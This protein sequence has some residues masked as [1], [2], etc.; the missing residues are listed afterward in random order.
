MSKY[1]YI[2]DDINIEPTNYEYIGQQNSSETFTQNDKPNNRSYDLREL[3]NESREFHDQEDFETMSTDINDLTPEFNE[4]NHTNQHN[5]LTI[6]QPIN[7]RQSIEEP[8]NDADI[9]KILQESELVEN[10]DEDTSEYK[11]N[12]N[13][14]ETIDNLVYKKYKT[15]RHNV[16]QTSLLDLFIVTILFILKITMLTFIFSGCFLPKRY[17]ISYIL[18]LILILILNEINDN[19]CIISDKINQIMKCN[20]NLIEYRT[21]KKSM[22]LLIILAILEYLFP[23]KSLYALLVKYVQSTD[24]TNKINNVV[25][26]LDS[27]DFPNIAQEKFKIEL[28][29]KERINNL[30]ILNTEY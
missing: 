1:S 12:N 2:D 4:T 7:T 5:T 11:R 21:L 29:N 27:K 24:E 25:K 9:D 16:K 20:T 13:Y 14:E 17:L 22:M 10:Y 23:D 3:Y 28:N 8:Y 26:N 6:N 15:M 18:V 19:T 30:V